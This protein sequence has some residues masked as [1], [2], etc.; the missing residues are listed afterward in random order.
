M[1]VVDRGSG[2]PLVLIPGLQGRWEYARPTV[3]ALSAFFR[4]IT[5]SLDDTLRGEADVASGLS[6]YAGQFAAVMSD[7][8]IERATVCGV[9]FGGLVA[10]RLAAQY[11]ERCS[12]LILASTP[13]PSMRLKK[14]H[15]LYMRAPWIFGPLFLVET[16]WRLRP[17]VRVAIPD[18]KARR[19]MAWRTLR[20]AINAPVSLSG[21]GAR[22]RM[23]G[24]AQ[25]AADCARIVAPTLLITGER[26]LDH[27]VPVDG[28]SEYLQRVA[29]ARAVVIERTGHL[30]SITR[31][32]AFAALVRDF[33]EGHVHAAA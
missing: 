1:D 10:V 5:V 23:I 6:R 19:R 21:M 17:E 9:S 24:G 2:P 15:Q 16:P 29:N 28:S 30:G 8:K 22:A 12:S 31:P 13:A 32:D 3:D 14:R 26:T 18:A 7:L 20:T 4:V 11:P 25:I 27:V 33:S